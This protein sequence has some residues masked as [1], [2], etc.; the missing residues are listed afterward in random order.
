MDVLSFIFTG[1]FAIGI[2]IYL[3]KLNEETWRK[4][5]FKI[6]HVRSFAISIVGY[7]L[8]TI[9]IM[10]YKKAL[11]LDEDILNGGILAFVGISLILYVVIKNI[12][13]T[14]LFRGIWL[15]IVQAIVY[16]FLGYIGFYYIVIAIALISQIR[17]VYVVNN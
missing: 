4:Y 14:S 11:R 16:L 13:R 2:F 8:T 3:I 5:G 7:I 10:W 17:P 6:F 12:Q 1:A 15:S 9:G